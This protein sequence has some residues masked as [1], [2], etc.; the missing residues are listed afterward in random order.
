M[1]RFFV[2]ALLLMSDV[3]IVEPPYIRE[4]KHHY[5]RGGCPYGC[6]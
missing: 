3:V 5:D 1:I 6:V 4:C 2:L